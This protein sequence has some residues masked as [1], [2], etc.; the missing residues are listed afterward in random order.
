MAKFKVASEYVKS[1]KG[2]LQ[3]I[4]QRTRDYTPDLSTTN[5]V[6]NGKAPKIAKQPTEV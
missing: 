6:S 3:P 1:P 4:K 5:G 2:G